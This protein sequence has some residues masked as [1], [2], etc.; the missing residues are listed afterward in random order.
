MLYRSESRGLRLSFP[1]FYVPEQRI[2]SGYMIVEEIEINCFKK[3]SIT[4]RG[5]GPES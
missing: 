1:E 3:E 4:K 5:N 2:R